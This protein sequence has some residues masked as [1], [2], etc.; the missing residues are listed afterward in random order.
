MRGRFPDHDVLADPTHWDDVTREMVLRRAETPPP[1]RF[2][3]APEEECLRAFLDVALAQDA[4]PRI[5]V[6]E[7]VDSKLYEGR[8]D[9][10]RHAGMP[11]DRATW[12]EVARRLR[13]EGFVGADER[14]RREIVGA[15]ARGELDWDGLDVA[16]AW[17]VV[18][19]AALSEFYSHPWAWN[20][21]G[22]GGPAYPRGYMRMGPGDAGREPHEAPEAFSTDPVQDVS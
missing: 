4:D 3:D 20:E 17:G 15:F 16:I 19:R 6:F 2:F 22:F 7:M 13:D 5:P 14:R 10:F 1:V 9:G 21:I 18:M 12:R 11:D 8:L